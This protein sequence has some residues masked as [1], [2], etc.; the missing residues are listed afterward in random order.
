MIGLV[1]SGLVM[2]SAAVASGYKI[3]EDSREYTEKKV[4]AVR[5]ETNEAV[6]EIRTDMSKVKQDMAVVRAILEERFRRGQ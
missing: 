3:K 5:Q 6:N 4:E 2:V 1:M